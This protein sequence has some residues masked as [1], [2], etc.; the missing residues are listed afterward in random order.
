M[1]VVDIVIIAFIAAGL[2]LAF[3]I[4]KDRKKNGKGCDGCN[5]ACG[6]CR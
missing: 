3:K 6:G 2:L 4:R 5:G 1:H